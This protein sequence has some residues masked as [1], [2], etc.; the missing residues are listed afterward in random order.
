VTFAGDKVVKV[1]ESYAGLGTQVAD[2]TVV[3]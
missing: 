1:E 3:R 2:P